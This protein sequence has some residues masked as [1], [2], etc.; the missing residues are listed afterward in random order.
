ML[1]CSLESECFLSTSFCENAHDTVDTM[2]CPNLD[3]DSD[4]VLAVEML[5]N[6]RFIWLGFEQ[7]LLHAQYTNDGNNKMDAGY[8]LYS[9]K[10]VWDLQVLL[11]LLGALEYVDSEKRLRL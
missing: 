7:H 3:R 11:A 9:D 10:Y 6:K 8:V 4:K 5:L 2:H 1:I